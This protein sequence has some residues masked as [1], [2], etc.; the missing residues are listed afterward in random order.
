MKAA[1]SLALVALVAALVAQAA[2]QSTNYGG[3]PKDVYF[4]KFPHVEREVVKSPLPHEVLEFGTD[5]PKAWNWADV[6]GENLIT[7]LRNQ[8]IP[9][10]C[11]APS[12]ARA[13]TR[14]RRMLTPMRHRQRHRRVRPSAAPVRRV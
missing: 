6:D 7:V 12:H 2:K 10:Y 11:G 1:L 4:K 3:M 9:T 5:V 8:H 14:R 13:H